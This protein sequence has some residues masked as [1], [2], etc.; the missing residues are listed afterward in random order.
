MANR[1]ILLP[2][3]FS[4]HA[5]HAMLFAIKLFERENCCFHL[6]NTFQVSPSGL[7]SK[8]AEANETRLFQSL[9]EES[10]ENLRTML[11]RL[12]DIKDN[13][14]HSF[15]IHSKADSVVGAVAGL[16]R[17]ED[18]S[19]VIM[20][21][22]GS[23]A[24]K[25]VFMGSTTVAIL[26]YINF[27]PIIAVPAESSLDSPS[28][29]AFATNFEHAYSEEELQPL[30]FLASLR[31]S[32]IRVVHVSSTTGLSQDQA[33]NKKVL[34][35]FLKAYQCHFEEIP[36]TKKISGTIMNWAYT[37]DEIGM[38]AMVSYHHSFLQK[39]TT[40]NIIKKVAFHTRLP[41]LIFPMLEI[42]N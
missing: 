13:A 28:A 42:G 12:K 7:A 31:C 33:E 15:R 16:C 9:R 39:L 18:I 11:E 19:Y 35:K 8:M 40:E 3:D 25:E 23:S 30:L 1:H 29:I 38:I 2:T 41:L 36:A 20:G 5:L 14:L 4:E 27:C 34:G 6:L 32:S 17:V 24:L 37:T 10:E 21:T 22:R 26:K